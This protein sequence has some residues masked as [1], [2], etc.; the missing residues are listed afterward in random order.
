MN[1]KETSLTLSKQMKTI[2][3]ETKSGAIIK[4]PLA[5]LVKS[6]SNGTKIWSGKT[7][8]IFS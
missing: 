8:D 6:E 2:V 1:K 5:Y 4:I 7:F 3:L